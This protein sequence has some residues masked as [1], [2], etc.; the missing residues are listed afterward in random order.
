MQSMN[1]NCITSPPTWQIHHMPPDC[2]PQMISKHFS[3]CAKCIPK[4]LQERWIYFRSLAHCLVEH[5]C[6]EWIIIT[7]IVVSSTTLV[8]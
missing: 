6:F 8:S 7:S 5:R 2:C 4:L 1:N 3:C